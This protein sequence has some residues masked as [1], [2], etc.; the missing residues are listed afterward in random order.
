MAVKHGP[1]LLILK[2]RIQAF[3]TKFMRKLLCISYLEC[4]TNDWVRGKI[5]FLMGPHKPVLA[6]VK[7]WKLAW[8]RHVVYHDSLS[9]S[10]LQGTLEGGQC[11]GWQRKCWMDNIKK[12]T[13]L[14]LLDLLTMASHRKEWKISAESSIMFP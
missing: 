5:N 4:K 10:I 3:E 14:P 9:K 1:C 2:K 6:T 8:F 12:W 7:R 13:S 11:H